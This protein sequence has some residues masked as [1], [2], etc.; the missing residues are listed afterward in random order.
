LLALI[1]ELTGKE[2]D[3]FNI[4]TS[5]YYLT[6][7]LTS[8]INNAVLLGIRKYYPLTSFFKHTCVVSRVQVGLQRIQAIYTTVRVRQSKKHGRQGEQLWKEEKYHYIEVIKKW[9]ENKF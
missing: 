2:L 8:I 5:L 4:Y 1:T 3:S 9:T 6:V 7:N